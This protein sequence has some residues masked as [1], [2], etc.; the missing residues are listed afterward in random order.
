MEQENREPK[1]NSTNITSANWPCIRSKRSS[2]TPQ[3]LPSGKPL[4]FI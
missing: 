3:T 2:V 4:D 1:P